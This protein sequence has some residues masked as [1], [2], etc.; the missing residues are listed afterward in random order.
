MKTPAHEGLR[1]ERVLGS[2]HFV[3]GRFRNPSGATPE[4]DGNALPIL[5]EYFFG[6]GE[7]VPKAVLPLERPH[8]SW[9]RSLQTGLRCTW[10]GHST[11]LLELGS[12]RVLTDPVFGER[13]SPV[14]FAGPKRFHP[15][16]AG[17]DELPPLDV[18][19]LSHNHYDHLCG[20]TMQALARTSVPIVTALGVG[21]DLERMGV[22]RERIFELDWH[23]SIELGD[24]RFTAAP[25]QHFS[26]RG[27]YDRNQS[28]WASWVIESSKHK[29]FFSGDT[30]LSPHFAEIAR[31]HGRF[32]LIML[33]VG[34]FHP[35]WGKIHLGPVNAL[36]AFRMLGGGTLMPVH[37][38]TFNLGMHP[39]SEPAETLVTLAA[40][41]NQ[42]VITP[43]LGSVIE[44]AH[45]EGPTP[46][47]RPL[48]RGRASA[49]ASAQPEPANTPAA[50]R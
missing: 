42:R 2:R 32:D 27:L 28:F 45:V 36:E 43:V 9:R 40:K 25:A 31:M 13:A 50:S 8:E 16:P 46:W 19:L 17:L 35:S 15:M 33:E 49:S 38:G 6:G 21:T 18:V 39:W 26:G 12:S 41:E 37:W 3:R 24:L 22:P 44:P 47:W 14:G 23:E 30:G 11:V 20:Q 34:A 10:L 1:L 5:G 7:R 4:L 48:T 29:L